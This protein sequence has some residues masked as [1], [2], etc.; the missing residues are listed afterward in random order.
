[1]RYHCPHKYWCEVC[2][3]TSRDVI[4]VENYNALPLKLLGV[5]AT[6]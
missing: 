2:L 3:E 4:D 6:R 5:R 1:M